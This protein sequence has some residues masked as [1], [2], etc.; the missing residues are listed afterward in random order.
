MLPV[1]QTS[2]NHFWSL[3]KLKCLCF[4]APVLHIAFKIQ[5]L[6]KFLLP[7]CDIFTIFMMYLLFLT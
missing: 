7:I 6:S 5:K 4:A 2:E 3:W 1:T